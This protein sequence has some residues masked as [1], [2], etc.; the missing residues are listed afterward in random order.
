MVDN[1]GADPVTQQTTYVMTGIVLTA[2]LGLWVL[3]PRLPIFASAIALLI[4]WISLF[5]AYA[6]RSS[7]AWRLV[8]GKGFGDNA[9]EVGGFV[10]AA[11]SLLL[12]VIVYHL[13][14][15]SFR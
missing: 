15:T 3:L 7:A 2:I 14:N 5:F 1:G 10:E 8:Y 12:V 4:S 9:P 13:V 11:R 6:G